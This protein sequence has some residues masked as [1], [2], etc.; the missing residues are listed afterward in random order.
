ML[1]DLLK[2]AV[3]GRAIDT[4]KEIIVS[5]LVGKCT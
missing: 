3:A 5:V 2:L 1:V 4:A